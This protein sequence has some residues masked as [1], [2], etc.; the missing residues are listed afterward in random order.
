MKH[1][2]KCALMIAI[3]SILISS[4]VYAM[5]ESEKNHNRPSEER[6]RKEENKTYSWAWINDELCVNFPAYESS[7][8][9]DIE[10]FYSIGM[11]P[12]WSDGNVAKT[13]D[14]YSG[15][16]SQDINGVK[17]FT[18]DDYTIPVGPTNIDSVIY[19]FNGYGQLM[20]GYNYWGDLTTGADGLVVTD[21]PE[22]TEWLAT[23][24]LPEC[25]S[26]E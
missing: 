4:N 22:F 10:W 3:I 24:Y 13:R 14:T 17:S 21:N 15:K 16:W 9:E 12:R 26:H 19:A 18:F 23:Q 25:T 6:H 5:G 1:R 8:M 2:N 11:I 20:D 7:G